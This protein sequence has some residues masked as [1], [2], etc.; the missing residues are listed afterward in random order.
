MDRL[1][2][3]YNDVALKI[4]WGTAGSIIHGGLVKYWSCE[5]CNTGVLTG[6]SS[7]N[8][9]GLDVEHVDFQAIN[10]YYIHDA[11]GN[12]TGTMNWHDIS[13]QWSPYGAGASR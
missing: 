11:N 7:T 10:T 6:A 2:T 9:Y 1:C 12:L 8:I 4:N 13:G 3:I 5:G